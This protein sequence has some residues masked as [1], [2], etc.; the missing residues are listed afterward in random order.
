M[1]MTNLERVGKGLD[2]LKEGLGPFV[3]REMNASYQKKWLDVARSK[4]HRDED[5]QVKGGKIEWDVHILLILMWE[6]WHTT[7]KRT[8]G[9][10]ERTYVSELRDFRKRLF[11]LWSE[12]FT[13]SAG[14]STFALMSEQDK[15]PIAR[16]ANTIPKTARQFPR[17]LALATRYTPQSCPTA[18]GEGDLLIVI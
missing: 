4:I 16:E 1:A 3:E 13:K 17:L 6:F 2:L 8:L 15:P 9:H 7:F 18:R 12:K 5:I 14:S 11:R 10:A